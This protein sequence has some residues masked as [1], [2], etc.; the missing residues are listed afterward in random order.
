[1]R[2][3]GTHRLRSLL[4][5][6]LTDL[7]FEYAAVLRISLRLTLPAYSW[8]T[9]LLAPRPLILPAYQQIPSRS[10]PYE[11]T[12]PW[13]GISWPIIRPVASASDAAFN[14]NI[15]YRK[16]KRAT[17]SFKFVAIPAQCKPS[18]FQP[19]SFTS[20]RSLLAPNP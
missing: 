9:T 15:C 13:F 16:A 5:Q 11:Q 14:S 12:Y 2:L 3:V 20:F 10:N 8:Q 17:F 1:M 7:P 18:R 19:S 4:T 6:P